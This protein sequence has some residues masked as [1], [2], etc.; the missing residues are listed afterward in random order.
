M[1]NL[2]LKKYLKYKLKY[3]KIKGG[4]CPRDF[5]KYHEFMKGCKTNG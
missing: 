5:D 3:I 1:D 2:Y 4:G